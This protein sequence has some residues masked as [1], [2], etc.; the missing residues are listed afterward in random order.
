MKVLIASA[1]ALVRAPRKRI[2]TAGITG[3]TSIASGTTITGIAG[4][5][6][7]WQRLPARSPRAGVLRPKRAIAIS[8]LTGNG[9]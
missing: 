7:A 9:N 1:F 2:G 6:K 5:L 8:L 4:E 3:T